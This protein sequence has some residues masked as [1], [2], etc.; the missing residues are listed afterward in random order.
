MNE[1]QIKK[2]YMSGLT[3]KEIQEKHDITQNKL[4]YLIQKNKWKRESNRSKV[5]KGNKNAKNNKG[6]KE[7]IGAEKGNKRALVTG[8]YENIFSGCFSNVEMAFLEQKIEIDRE[9]ELIEEYK[10][11][12]IRKSRMLKKIQKLEN[13]KDMTIYNMSKHSYVN[14][15]YSTTDTTTNAENTI[16]LIQRIEEALTRVQESMRKCLESM[17]KMHIDNKKL[18]IELAELEGDEIEDTSET[19]ADIYGS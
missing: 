5:Q 9:K 1:K 17:H 16:F 11:L 8:E 14:D 18:E 6:N 19:D 4:I 10:T 15:K 7:A 13:G 2:D 3:Y 12:Q